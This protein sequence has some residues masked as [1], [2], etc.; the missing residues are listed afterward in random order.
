MAAGQ[1]GQALG[2]AAQQLG[3][4]SSHAAEG[5]EGPDAQQHGA[6]PCAD[7]RQLKKSLAMPAL[8]KE[9]LHTAAVAEPAVISKSEAADCLMAALPRSR[10][11]AAA[12]W[13]EYQPSREALSYRDRS[14]T[15]ACPGGL[16]RHRAGSDALSEAARGSKAAAA[17][18]S[19]V[20]QHRQQQ[21]QGTSGP[22]AANAAPNSVSAPE[23]TS[24]SQASRSFVGVL[25]GLAGSWGRHSGSHAPAD[26]GGG[27]AE[28][29]RTPEM[30]AG[31]PRASA[32]Q[33]RSIDC[34]LWGHNR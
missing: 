24:T 28:D 20:Q 23:H 12:G 8:C 33:T 9:L 29:P 30:P 19:A 7:A 32:P 31:E 3:S 5:L 22:A 11:T 13:T 18:H 26:D 1:E 34:S 14:A 27:P 15:A 17:R 21:D 10:S 4:S 16:Q 6:S 25:R 2:G